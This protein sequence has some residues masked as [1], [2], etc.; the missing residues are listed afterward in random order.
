M[1]EEAGLLLPLRP[2][3]LKS[4]ADAGGYRHNDASG[5][6]DAKNKLLPNFYTPVVLQR[7]DFNHEG[8]EEIRG[9]WE[10]RWKHELEKID[11]FIFV[12]SSRFFVP[13]WF[14]LIAL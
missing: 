1:V 4:P 2:V 9:N 8:H 7:N 12:L 3:G 11:I 10:N 13:S 5:R 6:G 14:I